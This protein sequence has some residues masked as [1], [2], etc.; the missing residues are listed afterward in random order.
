MQPDIR[1]VMLLQNRHRLCH[2]HLQTNLQNLASFC[3]H[4][5]AAIW[6]ECP[7]HS[8][9]NWFEGNMINYVYIIYIYIYT[10]QIITYYHIVVHAFFSAWRRRENKNMLVEES[11]WKYQMTREYIPNFAHAM[12]RRKLE[13]KR[14]WSLFYSI[15]VYLKLALTCFNCM[16]QCFSM[17]IE[18]TTFSYSSWLISWAIHH[19]MLWYF[20]TRVVICS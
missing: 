4:L 8:R 1:Q 16:T 6:L 11:A 12:L 18:N 3:L 5:F 19:N 13:W 2:S 7:F 9:L 10:H 17:Q 14:E 15:V 20:T